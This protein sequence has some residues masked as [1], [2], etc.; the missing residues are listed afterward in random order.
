MPL[1]LLYL[2]VNTSIPVAAQ[3]LN[4]L[5]LTTP[6]PP[7]DTLVVGFLGGLERWNDDHRG[8]RKLA[9]RLRE[10]PGIHAESLSNRRFRTA[11]QLIRRAL[12]TNRDGKLD[13][14]EKAQARVV[15]YGQSLGGNAVV[16]MARKLNSWGVPVLLTAQVDSVGLRDSV[17]PPNVHAAVNYYQHEHLTVRGQTEIR[18]AD[19]A[20]THVL[21]NFRM[22]YPLLLPF[23]SPD[24]WHRK[25]FGGAHAR[26]EADPLL[27]AQL[28]I[29][30]RAAT[31]GGLDL[32]KLIPTES[33]ALPL[34]E[35]KKDSQ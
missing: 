13:P 35:Q 1:L 26:M 6:V 19:A 28:E 18:A 22:R 5:S 4:Q 8:V 25:I 27:W 9:I 20:K 31:S 16:K 24:E 34:L 14:Q 2:V 17:I 10:T 23:P 32:L 11:E 15:L 33:A 30:I 3:R 29:I 21:G 7:G 12:D